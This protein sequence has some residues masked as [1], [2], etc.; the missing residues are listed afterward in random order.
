MRGMGQELST[1]PV[2]GAS[3]YNIGSAVLKDKGLGKG[4]LRKTRGGP[5]A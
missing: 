4:D 5:H 1:L 2:K 3:N